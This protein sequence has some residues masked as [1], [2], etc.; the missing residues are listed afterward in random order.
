MHHQYHSAARTD[1]NWWPFATHESSVNDD[2][3]KDSLCTNV[4]RGLQT[5]D[6]VHSGLMQDMISFRKPLIMR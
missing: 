4:H 5:V 2:E 1:F 6:D 3:S